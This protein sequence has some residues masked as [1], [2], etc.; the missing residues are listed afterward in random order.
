MI[1]VG[2]KIL[3]AWYEMLNGQ[4]SVPVYRT[5]APAEEEGNYVIIR[6]ESDGSQNTNNQRFISN[7]VVITDVVTKFKAE[8]DDGLAADID[9]EI[10]LLLHSNPATH[11]L[12]SQDGIGITRVRRENA[13]Y[14][15]EDD[16]TF[17]YMR[18]VT[19][20]VHRVEQLVLT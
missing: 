13:T 19:R 1:N 3:K 10:S 6:I 4:L 5:D 11:N 2:N 9:N 16:G 12:P 14:I 15:P 20:N 7:P 17:R 18:I 8:I